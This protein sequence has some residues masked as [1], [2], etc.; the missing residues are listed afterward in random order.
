MTERKDA[1]D[2]TGRCHAEAL[3]DPRLDWSDERDWEFARRGFLARLEEPVI[4]NAKG[5]VVWDM[6][7]YGFLDEPEA[8][9]T[10]HPSLWRQARLNME[11]G[12]FRIHDRIYQ[13]RGHDLS[14]VSF[15]V[16]D[17]GYIVIDPLISAETARS[18]LD[19]VTTHVGERPVV[20]VIYTHSHIDHYGGVEGV[21]SH[22]AVAAGD[23]QVLA[24]EGFVAAA[25]A[26]N[27]LA[28]NVM[29][30]RA[31]Y[32]YGNLLPRDARGQ[33]D[34][35]LGKTT[36]RGLVGLIEP[37]DSIVETGSRRV[38]DGVEIEFQVTPDT[39]APA[40]MNFFFP[41]FSSLCMAENC[42]H[43]Q[44]NLY[45][46]RVAP[47]RDAKAWA[48]YM[49]EALDLFSDRTELV[50]TSHH[51][52]VWGRA[53]GCEYLTKQ[54]DMYKYLHDETL[55]LANHGLTMDEVAEQMQMPASLESE[56]YNRAYYG[57]V[58]HNAKAVYQ[59]Y[60][61][62]FDGNPAHL[63]PLPPEEAASRYVEF[64]GGAEAVLV[65]A[66]EAYAEGDYRWVAQV[67]DH[68]VFA[69]PHNAAARNL[70]ADALEQLGYQAE[71]ASWRNFYL[72][73]AQELRQWDGQRAPSSSARLGAG[74]IRSMD[75]GSLLDWVAMRL[76]GPAAAEVSCR[77][78]LEIQG[79]GDFAVLELGNGVL[80]YSL[81]AVGADSG[82]RVKLARPILN[83]LLLETRSLDELEA[84]G[85]V[86]VE[87]DR[88]TFTSL[89][90]LLDRFD[91]WFAIVTP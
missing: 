33:V 85:E 48:H 15:I 39:E 61:G 36:S 49:N 31:S 24:P 88:T 67:V 46:L 7:T 90:T 74:M 87:G 38:V 18:A 55:R 35:G 29:T 32:M 72:T 86:T 66:R 79:S 64:M 73:G 8:P 44:H 12:L 1:T 53:E 63:H 26:E 9:R 69:E 84:A 60:L 19:L 81:S 30:R 41:Q 62:F 14:V 11:H 91:R 58:N 82:T 75:L 68:V 43:N 65:K 25:I 3:A 40:E 56:W 52:P 77:I 2:F 37:T 83:E 76:N 21:T 23:V 80:N 70:E 6:T 34:A 59:R 57:S 5:R 47:V 27:V 78:D 10:V 4:R 42:S 45:T 22:E 16:G 54:R 50:F 17:H 51:W 28:G 13:V 71:S 89:L 20:A